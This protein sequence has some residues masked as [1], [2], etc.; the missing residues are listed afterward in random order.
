MAPH[1]D[2]GRRHGC[3][4]WRRPHGYAVLFF[5]G[6]H[7]SN[8]D[9][10]FLQES[11][12]HANSSSAW[13]ATASSPRCSSAVCASHA[14]RGSR[15]CPSSRSAS[16][17]TPRRAR[18]STSCPK[19]A[20]L[21][22]VSCSAVLFGTAGVV[23]MRCG[24]LCVLCLGACV[25]LIA[26]CD[27]DFGMLISRWQVLARVAVGHDALPACGALAQVQSGTPPAC[28]DGARRARI[29][30]SRNCPHNHRRKHSN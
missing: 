4:L 24:G 21:L 22:R 13:R 1:L 8:S 23:A 19:C 2:R 26:D 30:D 29:S 20:C 14:R 17:S 11:S 25:P 3:T 5:A 28:A 6:A 7:M 12:A 15:S 10:V 27:C 9:L 18:L 16:C